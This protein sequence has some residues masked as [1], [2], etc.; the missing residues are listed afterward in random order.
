[1][2]PLAAFADA[3]VRLDHAARTPRGH[4]SPGPAPGPVYIPRALVLITRVSTC[5]CGA[6]WRSPNSGVMIRYE[7]PELANTRQYR[8]A[9][10]LQYSRAGI[11]PRHLALPREEKFIHETV[12][13]CSACFSPATAEEAFADLL[14]SPPAPPPPGGPHARAAGAAQGPADLPSSSQPAP[15]GCPPAKL[16]KCLGDSRNQCGIMH[17]CRPR[18]CQFTQSRYAGA[19]RR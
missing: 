19:G 11:L 1:M 5:E 14:A 12:P 16:A 13:F 8:T 9:D 3:A 15:K 18:G 2:D 4:A 7:V 10:P 17:I 6:E